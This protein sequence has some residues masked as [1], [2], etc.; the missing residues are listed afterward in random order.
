MVFSHEDVVT[1]FLYSDPPS[2][3][4]GASKAVLLVLQTMAYVVDL[5]VISV[6]DAIS[7][8][9]MLNPVADVYPSLEDIAYFLGIATNSLVVEL[10]ETT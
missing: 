10:D 1:Y 9:N 6:L 3:S 4:S 5:V 2:Y 7:I 8:L